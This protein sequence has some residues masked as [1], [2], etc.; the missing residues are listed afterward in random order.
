MLP[1]TKSEL[2]TP[3]IIGNQLLG[4]LDVQSDIINYFTEEDALVQ[5]TLAAQ[6]AVAAQNAQLFGEQVEVA[7][8]LRE[9]DRLKSEF[10]ASMSHELRTPLNSIIGYAE[11]LLDGID[12]EL[13]GD[14][15]EDVSAI[16][17]SGKHLLNLIND[18]L[19]LAKIEAGQM[20]LVVEDFALTP[21]VEDM[22]SANRILL[23]DK[24]VGVVIDI[25]DDLPLL[26][27]DSLRVRQVI[28][29]L[30]TNAIKFTEQ[31][32]ITIRAQRY[33]PDP[34]MIHVTI[35]DSGIGMTPDQL[36]MIFDRFRQVDQSHTRRAGGTGLGLSITKQLVE[37]HGGQIWAESDYGVGSTFHFT[38][39]A[40]VSEE[41]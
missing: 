36:K 16:H 38:L 39:P 25:T 6:I 5:A 9:V 23:R 33:Q 20:D 37:L 2:A 31:G 4:V 27:A 34:G 21:L 3:M 13:T 19:D 7:D 26:H 30:L 41:V 17:G 12:G 24:T 32:D 10:L 8:Q 18:I 22:A 1:R 35:R 11:V 15:E 28:N 14:M 29:N 40:A